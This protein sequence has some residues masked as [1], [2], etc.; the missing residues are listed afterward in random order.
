MWLVLIGSFYTLNISLH[1]EKQVIY[2]IVLTCRIP[3]LVLLTLFDLNYNDQRQSFTFYCYGRLNYCTSIIKKIK[4]NKNIGQFLHRGFKFCRLGN[5]KSEKASHFK[6]NQIPQPCPL[7]QQWWGEIPQ[8]LFKLQKMTR[9]VVFG[10][11]PLL[12]WSRKSRQ[13]KNPLNNSW[14]RRSAIVGT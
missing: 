9:N 8:Q 10:N 6:S 12:T 4:C 1:I 2:R 7:Q 3:S 13:R 5:I 14:R 11:F